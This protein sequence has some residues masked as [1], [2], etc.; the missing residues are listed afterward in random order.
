MERVRVEE[1]NEIVDFAI[2]GVASKIKTFLPWIRNNF[3]CSN[4]K[5]SEGGLICLKGGDL[6]GEI[7]GFSWPI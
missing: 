1:F 6:S 7:S 3:S 5:S 2:V 4:L